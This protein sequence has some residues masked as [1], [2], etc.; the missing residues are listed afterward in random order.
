MK[1]ETVVIEVM[2]L[3]EQIVVKENEIWEKRE[4]MQLKWKP[5]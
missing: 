1:T 2:K 4:K 5:P 3:E